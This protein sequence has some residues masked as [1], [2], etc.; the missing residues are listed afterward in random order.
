MLL[1]FGPLAGARGMSEDAMH[2][3]SIDLRASLVPAAAVIP[4]QV[5]Y[6]DV[7]AVKKLVVGWHPGFPAVALPVS[8]RFQHAPRSRRP[9]VPPRWWLWP[10]TRVLAFPSLGTG[11]LPRAG[12]VRLHVVFQ[13]ERCPA[14]ASRLGAGGPAWVLLCLTLGWAEGFGD[15]SMPT[16]A[17]SLAFILNPPSGR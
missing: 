4:A 11:G 2:A 3:T 15:R 17:A 14:E 1:A 8:P 9:E 12:P 5:A 6:F 16:P 13:W 7:V 10:V